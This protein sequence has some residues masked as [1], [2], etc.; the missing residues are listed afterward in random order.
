[1]IGDMGWQL[2]GIVIVV[3]KDL[4]VIGDIFSL[5]ILS[6]DLDSLGM[7][8]QQLVNIVIVGVGLFFEMVFYYLEWIFFGG[9]GFFG[10]FLGDDVFWQCSEF[11]ISQFFVEGVECLCFGYCSQLFR[12]NFDFV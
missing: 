9:F 1:M 10:V 11:V 6:V 7:S 12:I 3:N 2:D 8:V 5:G 4:I